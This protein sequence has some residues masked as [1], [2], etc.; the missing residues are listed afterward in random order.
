[1]PILLHKVL[2]DAST[3]RLQLNWKSETLEQM[4]KEAKQHQRN[5]LTA[6][7]GIG[8]LLTGTLLLLLGPGPLLPPGAAL[9]AGSALSAIGALTLFRAWMRG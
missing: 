2:D 5:L 3:G 1:M 8:L 7:G 6:I 4:R 9:S